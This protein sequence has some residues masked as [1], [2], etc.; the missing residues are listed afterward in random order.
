MTL[1][2]LHMMRGD[3]VVLQG[4]MTSI[5]AFCLFIYSF[6]HSYIHSYIYIYRAKSLAFQF[7]LLRINNLFI[8]SLSQLMELQQ[9]AVHLPAT[10]VS[11][12]KEFMIKVKV[13][14]IVPLNFPIKKSICLA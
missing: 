12:K 9:A 3:E 8:H 5:F 4:N 13:D 2:I 7:F 6:I 10:G 14:S 1:R 11:N